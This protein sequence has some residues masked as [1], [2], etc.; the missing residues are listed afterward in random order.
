[1]VN[2]MMNFPVFLGIIYSSLYDMAG[3]K[4]QT[5]QV[6]SSCMHTVMSGKAYTV[7]FEEIRTENTVESDLV[8][9]TKRLGI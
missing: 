4:S 5:D 7:P 9:M 8:D 2:N 1:M 6:D 3:Q